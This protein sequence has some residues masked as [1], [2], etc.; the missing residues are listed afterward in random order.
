[1][2]RVA[3]LKLFSGKVYQKF[4]LFHSRLKMGADPEKLQFTLKTNPTT[5]KT[6]WVVENEKEHDYFTDIARSSYADMLH[7]H[8]RNHLY[9][10]AIKLAV[11]S[12]HKRGEKAKVLDIGTGTGLLSMMA[13]KSGAD[14]VTAIEVFTPMAEVAK[15]VTRQNGFTNI[16]IL[17]KHSTEVTFG[18]DGDM[19]EKANI[20]VT[21]LFD[22]ELIGEGALSAYQHAHQF[23]MDENCIAVPHRA[24]MYVTI[25]ESPTMRAWHEMKPIHIPRPGKTSVVV[26]PNDEMIQGPGVPA[27]HD[28]QLSQFPLNKIKTI[29]EPVE[30]FDFCWGNKTISDQPKGNVITIKNCKSG[31]A[32]V[33]LSWWDLEMDQHAKIILSTAPYWSHPTPSCMQWRDHWMQ[34]VYFLPNPCQC[35]EG[36]TLYLKANHDAYSLWFDLVNDEAS[37]SGSTLHPTCD[38]P[39]RM[40]WSRSRLGMIND[41]KRNLAFVNALE[42]IGAEI[43]KQGIGLCIS[44]FSLISL[45]V[46]QTCMTGREVVALEQSKIGHRG[47]INIVKH[48]QLKVDVVCKDATDVT[49]DLEGQKIS[50]LAGEPFFTSS[51]LPWHDLYFWYARTELDSY[52]HPNCKIMPYRAHLCIAAVEFENLWKIRAPVSNVEGFDISAMDELIDSALE[53]KEY[54]E[55]EPHALWEYPCS[56]LTSPSEVMTFDF[57]KCVSK[58]AVHANGNLKINIT[59]NKVCHAVVLWMK[60]DLMEDISLSTGIQSNTETNESPWSMHHK[61]AVF[62]LKKPVSLQKYSQEIDE[63]YLEY[64]L[65]FFVKSQDGYNAG[66][67]QMKFNV[68]SK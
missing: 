29:T 32:E 30:I 14:A 37:F 43:P 53:I 9:Y 1:M 68:A 35:D 21:E 28:I 12:I 62:F 57:Y 18:E 31:N 16:K 20:I 48:N 67:I 5:G 55:P 52:L 42:K 54:Y 10:E 7:D 4:C 38:Y 56:L 26:K 59:A 27:V 50:L 60:Y 41:H 65:T 22:T 3:G 45:L 36:G 34:S 46:A 23:L 25:V 11:E 13:A 24:I 2:F 44:D 61:Q 40:M 6:E 49:T 58:D 39:P 51:Y 33:V 19:K 8:E 15:T 64:N 17:N 63:P 47:L 66:D